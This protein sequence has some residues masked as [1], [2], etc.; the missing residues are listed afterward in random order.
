MKLESSRDEGILEIF[1]MQKDEAN[2]VFSEFV[3]KRYYDWVNSN[4]SEKPVQSHQV[5]K[6]KLFPILENSQNPVFLLVIDNLRFDQW[7]TIFPTINEFF[8]IE[9]EETYYSILPT[10]T[11]Y[12]R[13][14]FFSGLLPDQIKKRF[15]KFWTDEDEEGTKNQY[16]EE[17]FREQLKRFG[18]EYSFSYN[19]V[20]NI[21]KARK[22]QENLHQ[23]HSNDLNII[24]YNFVD[25]LSHARTEME[26]IKEL[27]QDEKAYR[28]LTLSWF[29]NSPLFEIIKYISENGFKLIITTDHGSIRVEK[30]VKVLG[31][32]NTNTNLRYKFG[33]RLDYNRKEVFEVRDPENIFLPKI[34]MS[35][36]YIFSKSKDFFVYPNNYNYYANFYKDSFQHGGISLEEMIIPFIVL[37]P[38]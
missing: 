36:S 24:V 32:K 5:V 11:Q 37:N 4:E 10:T 1:N 30:P 13:N 9:K 7:K 3:M 6:E 18:K 2:S 14:S 38:R 23:L 12:A 16:E 29:K 33:K 20:L 17:L 31:D 27:A 21:N 34:N 22:V 35:T 8:R 19:K 28:S 15:P 26:I 25:T